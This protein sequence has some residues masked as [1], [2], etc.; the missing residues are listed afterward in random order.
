[1]RPRRILATTGTILSLLVCLAT[2]LL[3][4]RSYWRADVFYVCDSRGSGLVIVSFSGRIIIP[5]ASRYTT[6]SGIGWRSIESYGLNRPMKYHWTFGVDSDYDSVHFPHW[7][8]IALT[9]IAPI[10]HLRR[11]RKAL[12]RTSGL[13][14]PNCGYDLRATPCRCPECGHTRPAPLTAPPKALLQR[15]SKNQAAQPPPRD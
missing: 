5:P 7:S 10:I 15:T 4:L 8:L 12:P 1:M 14:C 9:A 13:L 3:W 6:W 11:R 2:T